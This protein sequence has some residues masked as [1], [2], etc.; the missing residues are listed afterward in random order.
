MNDYLIDNESCEIR[1]QI[2]IKDHLDVVTYTR[3][4]MEMLLAN[5]AC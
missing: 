3:L 2:T 5:H 4:M 1:S